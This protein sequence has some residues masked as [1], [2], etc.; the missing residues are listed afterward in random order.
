MK[1]LG[2]GIFLLV[3]A[4][5][6]STT[7]K[8][9]GAVSE[10]PQ[11]LYSERWVMAVEQLSKNYVNQKV[12]LEVDYETYLTFAP[13]KVIKTTVCHFKSPVRKTLIVDTEAPANIQN[14]L[15][16]ILGPSSQKQDYN[17]TLAPKS[18]KGPNIKRSVYCTS[19]LEAKTYGYE[20]AAEELILRPVEE[21][22]RLKKYKQ[23]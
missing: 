5:C 15:I 4:A 20:I 7:S 22:L 8:T 12:Q 3:L 18:G 10:V 17:V 9:A 14:G 11:I 21:I 1:Q 6:S 2:S 13:N 23:N 19:A 16:K